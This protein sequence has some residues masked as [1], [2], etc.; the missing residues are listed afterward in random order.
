MIQI[1]FDVSRIDITAHYD[2]DELSVF[3]GIQGN[4]YN[5][6]VFQI[7][8]RNLLIVFKY[9]V[10]KG[11]RVRLRMRAFFLIANRIFLRILCSKQLENIRV[12]IDYDWNWN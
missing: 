8:Q 9:L 6:L 5:K 2:K 11:A 1:C 4:C 10:I 7:R 12:G 3:H